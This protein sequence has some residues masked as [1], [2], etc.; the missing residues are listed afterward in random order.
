MSINSRIKIAKTPG[1]I[2]FKNTNLDKNNHIY[3]IRNCND[4]D[5]LKRYIEKLKYKI[6]ETKN[7]I[8]KQ[9]EEKNIL[10]KKMAQLE[11]LIKCY[12]I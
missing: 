8:N 5:L 2:T 12:K 1:E 10:L 9:K 4:P 6:N 7:I 3:E 11:K